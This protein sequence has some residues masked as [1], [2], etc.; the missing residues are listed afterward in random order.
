MFIQNIQQMLGKNKCF[1][2]LILN[3]RVANLNPGSKSAVLCF[4]GSGV[5][6]LVRK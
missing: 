4:N 3:G 1:I 2:F 6:Q 5:N